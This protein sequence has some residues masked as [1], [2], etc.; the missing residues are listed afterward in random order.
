MNRSRRAIQLNSQ[1]V[2]SSSTTLGLLNA[3]PVG[4]KATSIYDL[5][6]ADRLYLFAV[7][8]TW[9]DSVDSPQLIACMPP[10]Y[11]YVEK[12]RP[13]ATAATLTTNCN[14]GGLCLFY[15]SFLSAREVQLP[16][17][18][19]DIEVLAV[20][21]HGARRNV[22]VVVLYRSGSVASLILSSTI[23]PTFSSVRWR[24]HVRSF[25]SATSTFI[26]TF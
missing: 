4:N 13:R 20:Y 25:C 18:T 1:P 15:A 2:S 7:V 26:W 10:G 19:S 17:C 22:L 14:H 24:T 3:R 5:I 16:S 9:H 23:L 11:R 6:V 12:A 8:E 21:L